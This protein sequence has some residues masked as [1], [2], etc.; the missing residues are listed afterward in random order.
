MFSW[1][2]FQYFFF[3]QEEHERVEKSGFYGFVN[4][5]F[6]MGL[7]E[8]HEHLNLADSPNQKYG[9]SELGIL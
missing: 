6:C 9:F 3:E 7:Q 4:L 1:L 2:E 5:V 8:E